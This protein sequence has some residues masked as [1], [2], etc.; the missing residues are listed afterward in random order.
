MRYLAILLREQSVTRAAEKL[1][2]SQPAVSAALSRLR[3]LLDDKLMVRGPSGISLTPRARELGIHAQELERLI[4]RI[5]GTGGTF[6]PKSSE[7]CFTIQST[8]FIQWLLAPKLVADAQSEAPNITFR[9]LQPDPLHIENSMSAGA[10]DLGIGY[11]PA[12]PPNLLQQHVM[13]DHYICLLRRGH[14]IF[15]SKAGMDVE[16]FT[17]YPHVQIM[18]RDFIM[19]SA[20]IDAALANVS[21]AR[22]IAAWLPSFLL[23]PHVIASTDM[24]AVVPSKMTV[25]TYSGTSVTSIDPPI[26]LPHVPFYMYW[27]P[28]STRDQGLQWLRKS[29]A[30]VFRGHKSQSKSLP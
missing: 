10:L 25:G 11:L 20:P 24:I 8:D 22:R 13:T 18:P 21:A 16:N 26:P 12:C 14:P 5:L 4:D 29:V 19:Y 3:S 27:H 6:D 7:R 1:G 23:L 30:R 28:R 9:F 17:K 2:V 15:K